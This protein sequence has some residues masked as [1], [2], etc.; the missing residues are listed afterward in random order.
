MKYKKH[1][2]DYLNGI[3]N[4]ATDLRH[5]TFTSYAHH[6]DTNLLLGRKPASGISLDFFDVGFSWLLVLFYLAI[7][8]DKLIY[9]QQG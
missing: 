9:F 5:L 7:F 4:L 8:H 2:E 1:V 6:H 3:K